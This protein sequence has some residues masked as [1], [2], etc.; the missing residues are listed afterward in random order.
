VRLCLVRLCLVRLCLVRL[1]LVLGF[2]AYPLV[3]RVLVV[4]DGDDDGYDDGGVLGGV[5]FGEGDL[6]GGVGIRTR[7]LR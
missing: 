1:C 4:C 3:F 7:V 5:L 2:P 6:L